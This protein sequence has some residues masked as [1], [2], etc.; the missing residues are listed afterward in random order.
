MDG[1]KSTRMTVLARSPHPLLF[2]ADGGDKIRPSAYTLM[3]G[4]TFWAQ[5]PNPRTFKLPAVPPLDWAFIIGTIVSLYAILLGYNA[6][7]GEREEGTLQLVLSNPVGRARLLT[8]KYLSILSSVAAALLAGALVSL[9]IIGVLSPQT[10]TY[11]NIAKIILALVMA[12]AYVSIYTFLSLLFSALIPR[13]S[14]VLLALLGIWV[15]FSVVIPSS[16]SVL[17][18]KLSNAPREVQTARMQQP[19]IDK[20][21]W[22]QIDDIGKKAQRGEFQTEE[23]IKAAADQAFEDGQVKLNRFYDDFDK[24]QRRK[25]EAARNLSRLSPA[26]LFQY[27]AES[28]IQSG[29]IGEDRFLSQVREY[30]RAYD[31]YIMKK[32]SKVVQTSNSSFSTYIE[33]K[34]KRISLH[35]PQPEEYQG[36]TSDFPRFVERRP[37]LGDGLR[38]AL[39]DLV[40]LILWNIVLAILAFYAFARTDVR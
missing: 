3:P 34:G 11:P 38:S 39:G 16:S 35:S 19:M 30:G 10:L 29:V 24:N 33:F 28:L 37:S 6:I 23:E 31:A 7:S 17:M 32:L 1:G 8:A 15:L 4:G 22:A 13:S 5:E 12:L 27:A 14:L 20:D 26:A 9:I 25:L 2:I 40:G 18:E 36:D 21:I